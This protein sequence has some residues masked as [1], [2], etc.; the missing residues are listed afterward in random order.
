MIWTISYGI[1]LMS[2]VV[3]IMIENVKRACLK[4][5][6]IHILIKQKDLMIHIV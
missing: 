1:K 2:N 3:Q 4:Y 6:E 5:T